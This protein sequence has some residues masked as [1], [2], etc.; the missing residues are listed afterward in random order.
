MLTTVSLPDVDQK[1]LVILLAGLDELPG[2]LGRA[3]HNKISA[4]VEQKLK[5][6]DE[7]SKN[8][9]PG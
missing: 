5:E 3:L 9:S 1:E 7:Q 8:D 6:H 4:H 2:K